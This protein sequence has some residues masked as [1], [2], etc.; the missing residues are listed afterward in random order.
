MKRTLAVLLALAALAGASTVDAATTRLLKA[1]C[2]PV[3]SVG[4]TLFFNERQSNGRWDA[5]EGDMNCNNGRP[6]LPTWDGHRGIGGVSADGN[7]VLLETD[8]GSPRG[9]SYAEPGKGVG[10]QLQLL[11]R[12][13]GR[14]TNLTTGRKGIIWSRLHDSGT[15]VQWAEMLKTPF[16]AGA[17]FPWDDHYL[18]VW[19]MH[20]ADVTSLGTLANERTWRPPSDSFLETYGWVDG[21]LV[22]ASDQSMPNTGWFHW[23]SAQLWSLPESFT[24]SSV[25]TR[26]S[27]PFASKSWCYGNSWCS[28]WYN[29]ES[30]YHEFIHVAL[31][32]AFPEPG[33]WILV[34]VSYGKDLTPNAP[35]SGLDLWRQ[36][37]DGSGRQRVTQFNATRYANVGSLAVDAGNPKR[38]VLAVA[39]DS[40]AS[41]IDAYEVLLP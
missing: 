1:N 8:F 18:G 41:S 16:E 31:P 12:S 34:G 11:Q 19:E 38:I 6:I 35:N 33:T 24:Q 17:L 39:G 5:R 13:T 28:E 7:L 32:G 22:F 21:Q 10:M 14:L 27:P 9:A 23:F 36:H 26:M 4:S 3:D 15:K 40:N 37:P 2:S 20:V 29:Y 25:P 30:P